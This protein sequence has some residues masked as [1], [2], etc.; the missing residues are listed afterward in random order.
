[1][2]LGLRPAGPWPFNELHPDHQGDMNQSS[3]N[4]QTKPVIV[5]FAARGVWRESS[6]NR[7]M[8]HESSD[9]TLPNNAQ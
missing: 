2:E 8:F 3:D 5:R 1:M 7:Q 4:R 6:G 9:Y